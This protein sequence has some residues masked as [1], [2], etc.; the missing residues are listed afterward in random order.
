MIQPN[1][2][3]CL[4]NASI[5]YFEHEEKDFPRRLSLGKA[6]CVKETIAAIQ[7][8]TDQPKLIYLNL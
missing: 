7:A 6:K 3:P 2:A 1:K 8:S 4:L 5:Q